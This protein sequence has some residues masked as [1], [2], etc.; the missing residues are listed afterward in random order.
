MT[1]PILIGFG[2]AGIALGAR[3]VRITYQRLGMGGGSLAYA[4]RFY[5]GG[6]DSAMTKREAAL[7]LGC[8]QS[9]NAKL[10]MERYR[11]LM[12][13]NHPDIGGSPYVAQKVN[14]AKEMLIKSKKKERS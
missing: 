10:V 7:I 9:A 1:T 8:R 11:T 5:D 2:I 14:E 12:K 4:K 3:A 13:L 6:F